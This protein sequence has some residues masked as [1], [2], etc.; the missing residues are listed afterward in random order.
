V[1]HNPGNLVQV[2]QVVSD[3]ARQVLG[4][5]HRPERRMLSPPL[6]IFWLQIQRAQLLQAFR[7]RPRKFI[8]QLRKRLALAQLYVPLAIKRL[9]RPTLAELQDDPRPR[10]PVRLFAVNQVSDN[11]EHVPAVAAFISVRPFFWQFAQKRIQRGGSASK[12]G[13]SLL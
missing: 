6:E 2:S 12:K 10:S 11:I 5:F 4:Q 7:T 3:P 1:G 8:Q 13:D 9:K